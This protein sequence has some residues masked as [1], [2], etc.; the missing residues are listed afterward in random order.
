MAHAKDRKRHHVRDLT[1]HW[2][3]WFTSII[4]KRE[5][6]TRKASPIFFLQ[7]SNLVQPWPRESG[8]VAQ[9]HGASGPGADNSRVDL[10]IEK[11]MVADVICWQQHFCDDSSASSPMWSVGD[12]QRRRLRLR[13]QLAYMQKS[14][15]EDSANRL[16]P[17]ACIQ[18]RKV[19]K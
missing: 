19:Q 12:Y 3:I 15:N 7:R 14:I 17:W 9:L 18:N 11:S 5:N 8:Q 16:N 10:V 13:M 6:Q 4:I 2:L 1:G